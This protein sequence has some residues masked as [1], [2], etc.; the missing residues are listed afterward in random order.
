MLRAWI[1]NFISL[2]LNSLTCPLLSGGCANRPEHAKKVKFLHI[3]HSPA[4]LVVL[5]QTTTA[6]VHTR[7]HHFQTER[8]LSELVVC[9]R[10]TVSSD[11]SKWYILI[12]RTDRLFRTD[13]TVVISPEG[14]LNF[15][16]MTHRRH[17][18][19]VRWNRAYLRALT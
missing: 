3:L 4:I 18:I 13:A 6:V 17:Q 16:P 1:S 2:K 11:W 19:G 8:N 15:P 5:H 14:P 10:I 7:T 9:V 12:C